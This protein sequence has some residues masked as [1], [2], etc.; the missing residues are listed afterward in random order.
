VDDVTP[1]LERTLASPADNDRG[2]WTFDHLFRHC[3]GYMVDGPSGHVGFVSEVIEADDV[4]E[5]VVETSCRE[6]HVSPS[7]I[8]EFDP[9]GERIVIAG[10][11][12]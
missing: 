6:L 3:E 4:V 7:E 12:R 10:G 9:V 8:E 11:A 1:Y 2:F 5:L